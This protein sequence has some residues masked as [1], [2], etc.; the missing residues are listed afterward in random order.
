MQQID[1]T[2]YFDREKAL[3]E[4]KDGGKPLVDAIMSNYKKPTP[5]LTP[6]QENKARFASSLTDSLTSLAEMFGHGQGA[7][8]RNREGKSN[9]QSTNERLQQ[10]RD[11]Y[12]KDQL[13][14]NQAMN[15]ATLMDM[16]DY[17]KNKQE[18]LGAERSHLLYKHK[19]ALSRE[20]A[21][22][23][24]RA[25]QAEMAWEKER[26]GKDMDHKGKGLNETIRHNK[27]MEAIRRA[28]VAA[29][30][31]REPRNLTFHVQ[32]NNTRM[33]AAQ[34]IVNTNVGAMR[35]YNLNEQE[36]K[37]ILAAALRKYTPDK[38]PE[39]YSKVARP[40]EF[41][42]NGKQV[43]ENKVH[44]PDVMIQ[45]FLEDYENESGKP[46]T[47]YNSLFSMPNS[48]PQDATKPTSVSRYMNLFG[49]QNNKTEESDPAFTF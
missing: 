46:V 40:G 34:P 31:K 9:T 42:F 37:N 36:Y 49:N 18:N 10:L 14:Y 20:A 22:A 25:K 8:I 30:D 47:P 39:L 41:D 38:N 44:N 13:R 4:W 3:Q 48:A 23:A 2:P 5:E 27:A 35:Q 32:P 45:K 26:F 17:L 29:K 21:E 15:D 43:F 16:R 33:N 24:A 6:E 7:R 1:N 12:E 28:D 11:K 19:D